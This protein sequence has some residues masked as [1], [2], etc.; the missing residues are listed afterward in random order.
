LPIENRGEEP[1]QIRAFSSSCECLHIEPKALRIHPGQVAKVTL[2]L[3]LMPRRHDPRAGRVRPFA[4]AIWPRTEDTVSGQPEN[5]WTVEGRVRCALRFEEPSL[6]FGSCSELEQPL[7]TKKTIVTCLEPVEDLI[8]RSTSHQFRVQVKRDEKD[9]SRF[10]LAVEPRGKL[11][12]GP[13]VGEVR[14]AAR[15]KGQQLPS[16]SLS[17][18]GQIVSDIQ[19]TPAAV[20]FGARSVGATVEENVVFRS[21]Q[22]QAITVTKVAAQGEGLTVA[23]LPPDEFNGPRFRVTQRISFPGLRQG[24][25]RFTIRGAEAHEWQVEGAVSYLGMRAQ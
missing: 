20:V 7:P 3:D 21:R 11:P 18:R 14:V 12:P 15:V 22:G 10:E 2:T 16:K 6:D 17:L 23:A 5:R 25:I 9:P 13:L 4:V 1:V 19:A 24:V 8:A